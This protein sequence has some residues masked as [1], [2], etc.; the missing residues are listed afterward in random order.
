MYIYA[1]DLRDR[2]FCSIGELVTLQPVAEKLLA[3]AK[4]AR[5]EGLLTLEDQIHELEY[6]SLQIG[7]HLVIA[8][9][10]PLIVRKILE[11]RLLLSN[12]AGIEF[13]RELMILEGLLAI[14]DGWKPQL[15]QLLLQTLLAPYGQWDLSLMDEKTQVEEDL[16]R[17]IR[18]I[19]HV[20]KNSDIDI[21][22]RISNSH[23]QKM[24]FKVEPEDLSYALIGAN[25]RVLQRV[26]S[27]I[28]DRA[29]EVLV[30]DMLQCQ[31]DQDDKIHAAQQELLRLLSHDGPNHKL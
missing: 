15:V 27:A 4:Q 26:L 25:T 11:T 3:M 2:T 18:K 12:T 19:Q 9:T 20:K 6:P 7:L 22:T 17:L 10:D 31:I 8:G 23:L 1:Y 30:S 21:I 28:S 16:Q 13:R 5:Y 24:L 14:Q 29:A